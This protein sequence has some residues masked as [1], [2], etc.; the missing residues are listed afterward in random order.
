LVVPLFTGMVINTF[1]QHLLRIGGFTEVLNNV[2]YP[3]ILGM[4][5]FSVGTN[6]D[7]ECST[8]HAEA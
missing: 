3:T 6:D 5:R 7:A 1:L 4:Y 2:G 8:N